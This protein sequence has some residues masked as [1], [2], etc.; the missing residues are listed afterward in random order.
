MKRLRAAAIALRDFARGFL[1]LAAPPVS[2]SEAARRQ[3]RDAAER[4]P[5]CC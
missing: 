4:R 5:H 2:S 1:G 3:I